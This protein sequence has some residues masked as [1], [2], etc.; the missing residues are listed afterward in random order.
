MLGASRIFHRACHEDRAQTHSGNL[1]P[2]WFVD[3]V[4]VL[5]GNRT[6]VSWVREFRNFGFLKSDGYQLYL[7]LPTKMQLC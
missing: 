1:L 7:R 5:P 4:A 6:V 2:A 3:T